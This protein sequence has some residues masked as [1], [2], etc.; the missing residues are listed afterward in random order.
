MRLFK[1]DVLQKSSQLKKLQF[2]AITAI[3]LIEHLFLEELP[4][5]EENVFGFLEPGVVVI[6]TPNRDF[7]AHFPDFD[8]R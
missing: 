2:E 7:N 4:N 8:Q 1:V 3:E 5:F 6:T